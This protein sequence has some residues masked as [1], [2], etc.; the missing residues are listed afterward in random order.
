MRLEISTPEIAGGGIERIAAIRLENLKI[1]GPN[2][3]ACLP[4]DSQIAQKL[5]AVT[6]RPP[7]RENARFRDLV[8]LLILRE[9]VDSLSSLRIACEAVF[10]HRATHAWLPT[11]EVPDGWDVGYA[12]LAAEVG[13]AIA[14]VHLAAGQVRDFIAS[15]AVA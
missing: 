5:H 14:D 8:D 1:L 13:L 3:I 10:A 12:A 4:L 15:I 2:E 6:E 7:D 9:L 11:L